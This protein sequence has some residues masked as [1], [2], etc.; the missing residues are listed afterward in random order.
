MVQKRKK[1]EETRRQENI[2]RGRLE[3]IE[4]TREIV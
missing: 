2:E 3:K 4:P 1:R